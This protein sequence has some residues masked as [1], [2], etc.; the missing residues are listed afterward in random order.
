MKNKN[1]FGFPLEY[2]KH[3][4]GKENHEHFDNYAKNLLA[5]RRDLGK[6]WRDKK[7]NNILKT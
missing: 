2:K 4:E 6:S 1:N 5:R 3:P 7:S